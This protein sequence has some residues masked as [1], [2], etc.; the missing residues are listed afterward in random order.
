MPNVSDETDIIADLGA[1]STEIVNIIAKAE[2]KFNL[3][4]DD[5]EVD[6]LGSTVGD[7]VDLILKTMEAGA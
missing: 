2:E 3:E 5:D 4:F 7:S 1:P 6:D